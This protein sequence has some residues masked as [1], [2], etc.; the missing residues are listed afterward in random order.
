MRILIIGNGFD[1]AHGL[2]T[3]YRDFLTFCRSIDFDDASQNTLRQGLDKNFWLSHFLLS[4]INIGDTWI[5]F[6]E[7]IHK[8]ISALSKLSVGAKT[9]YP[10]FFQFQAKKKDSVMFT[11]PRE[12]KEMQTSFA[13][14]AGYINSILK[15]SFTPLEKDGR[16]WKSEFDTLKKEDKSYYSFVCSSDRG[17]STVLFKNTDGVVNYAY[18]ELRRFVMALEYYLA[19][20]N[21]TSPLKTFTL[22]DGTQLN[23]VLSFNYT[24]TFERLY[25]GIAGSTIYIHGKVNSPQTD[26]CNMVLGTRSFVE[27]DMIADNFSMFAKY[28]QR[29]RYDNMGAYQALLSHTDLANNNR[30]N[31]IGILGHSLDSTD[32]HLIKRVL[33]ANNRAQITVFYHSDV[34]K[35]NLISKLY[36]I[37][38][39]E[40]AEKRVTF[41]YQHDPKRGLLLPL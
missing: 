39:E 5:D 34:A 24:N 4:S 14:E 13:E 31:W 33:T 22:Q 19:T 2:K 28:H 27:S 7:E 3:T 30:G 37:L 23:S 21:D 29:Q 26:S 35:N 11:F 9:S 40:D 8:A 15:R 32:K 25:P 1:L 38:G 36:A 17:M 41:T 12:R 16:N 18:D 20:I 6:E 10:R